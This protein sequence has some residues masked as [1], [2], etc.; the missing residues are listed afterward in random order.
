MGSG[1][2]GQPQVPTGS[3]MQWG[4]PQTPNAST[5]TQWGQNG[6]ESGS[7]FAGNQ[8]SERH[9]GNAIPFSPALDP[10]AL[11]EQKKRPRW[12]MI[13]SAVVLVLVVIIA[14]VGGVFIFSHGG[15]TGTNKSTATV[16]TLKPLPT[17]TGKPLFADTFANNNN[18]WHLEKDAKGAFST[19][20]SNGA[21][22]LN[23]ND[24][25]LFT[26][27][28]PDSKP[29][30]DFQLFVNATLSKGDPNPQSGGGGYGVVIR[31]TAVQNGSLATFYR[32]ELYGDGTYT[33]FK[34]QSDVAQTT[35]LEAQTLVPNAANPAIQPMG[36]TNQ[37]VVKAKGSTMTFI[38]NGQTIKTISDNSYLSGSIAFF[39]S[40]LPKT[41]PGAEAQF[42]NL[43]IFPPQ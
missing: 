4:Q 35:V 24:N 43:A 20:L 26:E 21:L 42:T 9:T 17:P 3:G 34:G 31:T 23:D 13:I 7:P 6:M 19:S 33:I 36:K 16:N 18:G 14:S 40:N 22:T 41:K 10:F 8:G 5:G 15:N 38:V 12:G 25:K 1:Q 27:T 28:L 37:I 39:V 30:G 11:S 32:L 2:W 29:Y